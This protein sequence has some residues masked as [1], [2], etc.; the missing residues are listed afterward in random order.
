M[1]KEKLYWQYEVLLEKICRFHA[2]H[3]ISDSKGE[4]YDVLR[5]A[6]DQII[7]M[8]KEVNGDDGGSYDT[9]NI[10]PIRKN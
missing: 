5:E 3:E 2:L 1:N 9:S 8:Q 10:T 4:E 6:V 7:Q